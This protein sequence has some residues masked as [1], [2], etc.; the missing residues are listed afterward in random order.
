MH[1]RGVAVI[2]HAADLQFGSAVRLAQ[3]DSP[4]YRAPSTLAARAKSRGFTHR[5]MP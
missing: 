1:K 4:S 2:G 3:G 5:I